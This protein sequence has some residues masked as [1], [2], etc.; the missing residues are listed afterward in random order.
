MLT[1]IKISNK[2]S[3]KIVDYKEK[4]EKKKCTQFIPALK[5]RVFL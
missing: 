5:D 4:L 2:K 3:T 1:I